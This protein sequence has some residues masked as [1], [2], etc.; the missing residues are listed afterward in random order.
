MTGR[1]IT[2]AAPAETLWALVARPEL[3]SRWSPHVRGAEGLGSP[4]VQA[5]AKGK[6]ILAGGLRLP[7]EITEVLPGHSWSWQ[8]GGILVDHVVSE[9]PGGSTLSMPVRPARGLWKPTALAYA[10]VVGLIAHRIVQ[11]AER[12]HGAT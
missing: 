5:G 6:V 2:C 7:A 4:E 8:V 10:P 3:W 1:A 11:I 12:D 9:A